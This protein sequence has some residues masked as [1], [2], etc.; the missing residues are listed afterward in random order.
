MKSGTTPTSIYFS[1]PL[2]VLLSPISSPPVHNF[3]TR[4]RTNP[5]RSLQQAQ[6]RQDS[7]GEEEHESGGLERANPRIHQLLL[8]ERS[9]LLLFSRI[10]LE[11][12]K[13]NSSVE[14]TLMRAAV[15]ANLLFV[16]ALLQCH[17]TTVPG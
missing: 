9:Y 2:R 14:N 6:R 16:V 8:T 7:D 3:I 5:P 11:L 12:V 4:E 17:V 10:Y 13:H 15:P 1:P